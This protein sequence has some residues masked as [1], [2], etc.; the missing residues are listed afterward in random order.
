MLQRNI[1]GYTQ[2]VSAWPTD[3]DPTRAPFSV[4]PNETKDFP[5]LLAGFEPVEPEEST[6]KATAKAVQPEPQEGAEA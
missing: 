4:G 1:S 6:K 5:E 2:H 3:E